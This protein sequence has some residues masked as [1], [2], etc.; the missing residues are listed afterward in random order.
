M[1]G[2]RRIREGEFLFRGRSNIEMGARMKFE[3]SHST[4]RENSITSEKGTTNLKETNTVGRSFDFL[5]LFI[6]VF[7]AI[8]AYEAM[9][10]HFQLSIP[11]YI[12]IAVFVLLLVIAGTLITTVFFVWA[13]F[14]KEVE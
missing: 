1:L 7:L 14:R 4:T 13:M 2:Y 11:V 10:G 8:I 5:E 3:W 12:W 9:R 6:A